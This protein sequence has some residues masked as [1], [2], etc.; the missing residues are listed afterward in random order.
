[1]RCLLL[2]LLW[3]PTSWLQAAEPLRI[4]MTVDWEGDDLRPENLEAMARLRRE[5]PDVP[6]LHY[7]NAAYFTKPG[8][9]RAAVRAQIQSVVRKKD[10]FGVHIHGWKSL[11]EAAGVTHRTKPSWARGGRPES[12]QDCRLDCG[13]E[14]PINAYTYDELRKVLKTSR[15]LLKEQGFPGLQHFRA[16]GWVTSPDLLEALAAEGFRTDSS[17]VPV[18]FLASELR[19]TELLSWLRSY[20]ADITPQSQP[21]RVKTAEGLL[22]QVPN[23]AALA[24][25]MTAEATLKVVQDAW[26]RGQPYVIAG[27]HQETADDWYDRVSG[28]LRSL[29]KLTK[30]QK[31]LIVFDI[32]PESFP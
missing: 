28:F 6:L 19:G 27:F 29:Q 16:G 5:F 4:I 13:W 12:V 20:W 21:Y 23:N 17:A 31:A 32:M 2:L 30:E 3:M 24:D 7:M 14:I 8:V 18:P 1:M 11:F 26:K 10:Q 22:W 9:D 25:Y 15:V